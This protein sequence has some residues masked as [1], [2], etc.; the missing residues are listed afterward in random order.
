MHA[1]QNHIPH[2]MNATVSDD[3]FINDHDAVD[4][5][6]DDDEDDKPSKGTGQKQGRRKIKI[7][8]IADKS[9]RHITFSKRKAGVFVTPTVWPLFFVLIFTL[10]GIM[11]KVIDTFFICL[12]AFVLIVSLGLR[13]INSYRHSGPVTR[14]F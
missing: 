14:S 3:A 1:S 2:P 12:F 11:K 5:A 9:R 6:D 10:T 8:F 4:S 13:T 7:E